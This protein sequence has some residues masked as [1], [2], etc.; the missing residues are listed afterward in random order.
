MNACLRTEEK[1]NFL[2]SIFDEENTKHGIE[3][4]GGKQETLLAGQRLN[5][6][7]KEVNIRHG[8][9]N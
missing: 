5:N 3:K 9:K 6:I 7:F 1:D 8:M 4:R 2:D